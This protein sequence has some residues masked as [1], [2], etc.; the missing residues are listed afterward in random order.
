MADLLR[1]LIDFGLVVLTWTVQLVVYPGFRYYQAEELKKWHRSYTRGITM[2]V[3]PLMTGQIILHGYQAYISPAPLQGIMAVLVLLTWGIT[4]F[5]AVPLHDRISKGE[6]TANAV[7]KLNRVHS[8]RTFIW[9]MIFILSL[10][11]YTSII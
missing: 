3:L 5:A 1:I 4:F 6:S 11:D 8:W 10:A 9:T 2:V 7:R